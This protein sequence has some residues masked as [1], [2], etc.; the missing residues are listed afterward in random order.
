M[1]QAM[2]VG[3]MLVGRS[4]VCGA[5]AKEPGAAVLCYIICY[6]VLISCA[7]VYYI[8]SYYT[9]LYR[10]VIYNIVSYYIIT[11]LTIGSDADNDS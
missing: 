4:G 3:V 2:L 10:T 8:L 1:S 7:M 6:D 5:A 9:I 11:H